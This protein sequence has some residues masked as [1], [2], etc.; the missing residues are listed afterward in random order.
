MARPE[1]SA[2]RALYGLECVKTSE[3]PDVNADDRLRESNRSDARAA[4]LEFAGD[5]SQIVRFQR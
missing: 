1:Q 5:E 2:R 4:R 3:K